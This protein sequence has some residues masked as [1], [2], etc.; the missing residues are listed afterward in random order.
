MRGYAKVAPQLWIGKTGR[1]LRGNPEAQIVAFY[2]ISNPHANMLGLY[3]LPTMLI[4]HET[5]LSI[6][7]TL[8]GL[9]SASEAGFCGYDDV[10]EL[11]WVF[12]MA[13]FQ[14]GDHL[15]AAD[16]RCKGV[17]NEYDGLPQTRFLPEFFEK[18]AKDFH[19]SN[20]REAAEI[21]QAPSK[22]HRCQE[23]E[24]EQELTTL[25]GKPDLA[26]KSK[27]GKANHRIE[28]VDVL[29]YLN[30]KA[31]RSYQSV[32]ANIDLIMARLSDGA[33]PDELRSVIERKCVQ[34]ATDEKMSEFLRPKTL[35]NRTNFAQY[36]G[37]IGSFG[38]P[39][40]CDA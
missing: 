33:T 13:K 10:A 12:E 20:R 30:E 17:Q 19:L 1:E 11:V 35:F 21:P 23:Q 26:A 27:N 2:L 15:E 37:E 31:G 4:S 28:A 32:P 3:Y 5:G 38:Q 25:S 14:I 18:Y 29:A 8:K 9:R 6:E 24:Q 22:P 39:I 7:G 16:K 34:W 40:R 36:Q